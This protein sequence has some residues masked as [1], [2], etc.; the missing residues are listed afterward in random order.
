MSGIVSF[1]SCKSALLARKSIYKQHSSDMQIS[2]PDTFLLCESDFS[3]I[4]SIIND[5]KIKFKFLK[6]EDPSLL[7]PY[8]L[9]GDNKISDIA[10]LLASRNAKLSPY[11]FDAFKELKKTFLGIYMDA[12]NDTKTKKFKNY[13]L[14]S[15]I[16]FLNRVES[17]NTFYSNKKKSLIANTLQSIE[18]YKMRGELL[19]LKKEYVLFKNLIV[20]NFKKDISD[21]S[22]E[23]NERLNKSDLDIL[24]N[25][26]FFLDKKKYFIYRNYY[27]KN[28]EDNRRLRDA[29]S[30]IGD[31]LLTAFNLIDSSK[32]L[33]FNFDSLDLYVLID[34]ELLE[35]IL[36]Q[37]NFKLSK[38]IIKLVVDLSNDLLSNYIEFLPELENKE[39]RLEYYRHSLLIYGYLKILTK[40]ACFSDKQVKDWSKEINDIVKCN[41]GELSRCLGWLNGI[42]DEY[43][44]IYM[45]TVLNCPKIV[46][47]SDSLN[48]NILNLRQEVIDKSHVALDLIKSYKSYDTQ[49]E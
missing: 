4:N 11:N 41:Q 10:N 49:D 39:D 5:K 6:I 3:R 40:R 47:K 23:K 33:N 48:S 2:S 45:N 26:E 24:N 46:E 27:I 32:E 44:P 36:I 12:K 21:I 34:K 43:K 31:D 18:K 20:K 17:V 16:P 38:K 8:S 35:H 19:G 42:I 25:T 37:K 1:K 7:G 14:I 22:L 15:L 9:V 28:Y 30:I 29:F 13:V